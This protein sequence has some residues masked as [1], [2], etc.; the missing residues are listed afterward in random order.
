MS[1]I[2]KLIIRILMNRARSRTRP[3]IG[4]E[5]CGF[6]AR[7]AIFMLRMLSEREIQIQKDVYLC[8]TNYAKAFDK[9][10]NKDLLELLANFYIFGRDIKIMK[11]LNWQQTVCMRIENAFSRYTK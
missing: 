2:T 7:N 5:Q 4:Q 6:G 3:E 1:H 11:T 10:R 9:V 8:F